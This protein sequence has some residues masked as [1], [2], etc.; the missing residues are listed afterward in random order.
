MGR[1]HQGMERPGVRQVPEDSGKQR[2]MKETGCEITSGAPTTTA[3]KGIDDDNENSRT[4]DL[5]RSEF[6]G[7]YFLRI[8]P[9]DSR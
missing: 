4:P 5:L 1:K 2:K 3:V 9:A 7:E 6:R 8:I